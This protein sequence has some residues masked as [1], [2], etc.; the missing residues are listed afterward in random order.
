MNAAQMS[1][2][3]HELKREQTQL[4]SGRDLMKH[5]LERTQDEPTKRWYEREL[6]VIDHRVNRLS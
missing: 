2:Y 4:E 5:I 1:W 6:E 3:R